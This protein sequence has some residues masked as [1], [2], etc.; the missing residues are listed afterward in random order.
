MIHHMNTRKGNLVRF[1][2]DG[3]NLQGRPTPCLDNSRFPLPAS[4]NAAQTEKLI[5]SPR[6]IRPLVTSQLNN[7][8]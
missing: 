2:S 4:K 8:E 6:T 7:D 3:S 1:E 5:A